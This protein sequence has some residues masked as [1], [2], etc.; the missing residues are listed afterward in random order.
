MI[1]LGIDPSS[2]HTGIVVLDGSDVLL[3]TELT[4]PG[5]HC[6]EKVWS[7][8]EQLH[9]VLVDHNVGRACIEGYAFGNRHS[10]ATLVEVGTSY[11]VVLQRHLHQF[12]V[13]QP[14]QLKK[15]CGAGGKKDKVRLAVYKQWGY[16]HDSD[17]VVD[18][19]VLARIA[20]ALGRYT[21]LGLTFEQQ[22]VRGQI[23]ARERRA[24]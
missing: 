5:K 9:P 7:L 2:A 1:A 24:K 8:A 21:P 14:T 6:W 13:A 3:E 18:A 10:L 23:L 16:E 12:H 17:N 4:Y 20:Q 11:R 22:E 15:F 19:Y